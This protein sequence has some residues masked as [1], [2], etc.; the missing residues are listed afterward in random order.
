MDKDGNIHVNGLNEIVNF[1]D[2][3]SDDECETDIIG[4]FKSK[5]S[6]VGMFTDYFVINDDLLLQWNDEPNKFKCK[7]Y[8]EAGK[9]LNHVCKREY[10]LIM[11]M[12]LAEFIR[13][14]RVSDDDFECIKNLIWNELSNIK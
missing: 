8:E 13:Y 4:H 7:S 11:Y 1:L 9:L 12:Y 5:I 14:H 2:N 3:V 6:M 10:L